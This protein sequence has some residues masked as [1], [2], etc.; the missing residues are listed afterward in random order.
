MP[1]L[2]DRDAKDVPVDSGKIANRERGSRVSDQTIDLVPM[3]QRSIRQSFEIA[4]YRLWQVDIFR[5]P[6]Q[7]VVQRVIG[8]IGLEENLEREGPSLMV[9]STSRSPS[10]PCSCA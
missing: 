3:L 10:C 7:N 8:Q 6:P 1:Q 2:V 4:T 9:L 5:M